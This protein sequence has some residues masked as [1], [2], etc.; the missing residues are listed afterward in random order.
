MCFLFISERVNDTCVFPFTYKGTTY[1]GCTSQDDKKP[2]CAYDSS[3][4]P[5]RWK[6]CPPG[7][8]KTFKS[9]FSP[10]KIS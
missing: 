8:G 1:S 5:T 10:G 2:W 4:Q 9:F 3:Y 7:A 6:Y